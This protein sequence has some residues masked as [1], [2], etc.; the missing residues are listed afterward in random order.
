[1]GGTFTIWVPIWIRTPYQKKGHMQE[2]RGAY[3]GAR[4]G[5]F[6]FFRF[7]LEITILFSCI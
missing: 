4:Q 6:S 3:F 5:G 1:M 2:N 7:A